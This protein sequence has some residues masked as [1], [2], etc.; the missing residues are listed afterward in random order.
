MNMIYNRMTINLV[1]KKPINS[2]NKSNKLLTCIYKD[3]VFYVKEQVEVYARSIFYDTKN[4]KESLYAML[5][6]LKHQNLVDKIPGHSGIWFLTK[7]GK[8]RVSSL[9]NDGLDINLF[10]L[11]YNNKLHEY[12]VNEVKKYLESRN[13]IVQEQN[14]IKLD[15][16]KIAIKDAL[17][18]L[19]ALHTE[20]SYAKNGHMLDSTWINDHFS[21][22]NAF[23]HKI[24]NDEAGID[25]CL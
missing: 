16:T 15:S 23:I 5:N 20:L 18:Y 22:Q 8:D 14:P 10:G 12:A 13:P 21:R 1:P 2:L 25:L 6:E 11:V 7:K 19:K 3:S 24:P 4:P 9:I 17:K